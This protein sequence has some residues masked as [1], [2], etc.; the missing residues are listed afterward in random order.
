MEPL[1][2]GCESV[3]IPGCCCCPALF[4]CLADSGNSFRCSPVAC[5]AD[6]DSAPHDVK[7]PQICR[8]R[9]CDEDPATGKPNHETL[10]AQLSKCF[11]E[12][13]PGH[14]E[15]LG[16]PWF[17]EALPRL[18]PALR[19][20]PAKLCCHFCCNGG[21]GCLFGYARTRFRPRVDFRGLLQFHTQN[22]HFLPASVH[23]SLNELKK[24]RK[25]RRT[26]L[27]FGA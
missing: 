12:G 1:I 22:L 13:I 24:L 15:A 14:P 4:D 11:S 27:V 16:Q 6:L 18:E 7:V 17:A 3:E 19:E 21:A 26:I 9:R 8:A 5:R 25:N 10:R 2:G 23:Q 20:L